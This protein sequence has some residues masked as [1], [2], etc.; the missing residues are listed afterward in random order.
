MSF[1]LI[2]HHCS[3]IS[4][5]IKFIL[6]FIKYHY[7]YVSLFAITIHCGCISAIKSLSLSLYET[8]LMKCEHYKDSY[9]FRDSAQ[10]L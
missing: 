5:F 9:Y 6:Y 1:K 7:N 8:Q 4:M 2:Y 10:S 3:D